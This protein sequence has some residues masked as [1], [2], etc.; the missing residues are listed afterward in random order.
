MKAK[1]LVSFGS[2]NTQGFT[3]DQK[4]NVV[5]LTF[6]N[7]PGLADDFESKEDKEKVKHFLDHLKT[8]VGET[9]DKIIFINSIGY[10]IDGG[11]KKPCET[12]PM[13]VFVGEMPEGKGLVSLMAS[14]IKEDPTLSSTFVLFNRN[15]KVKKPDGSIVEMGGQWPKQL[16]NRRILSNLTGDKN[17]KDVKN[18]I[19]LGGGSGTVYSSDKNGDFEKTSITLM[20]EP[21]AKPNDL[22]HDTH[23][24]REA[25]T[26]GLSH[27]STDHGILPQ[28]TVILQTGKARDMRKL[29]GCFNTKVFHHGYI[30]REVEAQLEALDFLDSVA[31]SQISAGIKILPS[32]ENGYVSVENILPTGK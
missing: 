26:S 10:A 4:G 12:G 1:V 24:F 27:I 32:G 13:M 6:D 21:G 18:I 11:K 20:D 29:D 9:S 2:T 14:I 31:G 17:T 28:E 5:P 23:G 7:P 15:W 25:L 22:Y 16:S 19:D 30:P 3:F 8:L